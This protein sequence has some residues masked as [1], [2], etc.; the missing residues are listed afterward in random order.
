MMD[1][2]ENL[3]EKIQPQLLIRYSSKTKG[4][5]SY[6]KWLEWSEDEKEIIGSI[7]IKIEVQ[8]NDSVKRNADERVSK[9]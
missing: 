3:G 7:V 4:N 6:A 8:F 9:L 5:V 2:W 1:L